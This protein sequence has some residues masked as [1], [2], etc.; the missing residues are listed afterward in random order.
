MEMNEARP[1]QSA[2]QL[3]R[4]MLE[5][6]FKK[7]PPRLMYTQY[8]SLTLDTVLEGIVRLGREVTPDFTLDEVGIN[9]YA[10]AL[11]WLLGFKHPEIDDPMKGIIV[12]GETGVGKTLMVR[13]LHEVSTRLGIHR[14]FYDG[15]SSRVCMKPFLWNY[16]THALWHVKD[17]MGSDDGSFQALR[18]RVLHIGDLGSEPDTFHRY[19]NRSSLADLINQRSD[20]GYQSAPMIITTNLPWSELERYGDRA[21]SRLRGDCIEIC[22]AGIPDHRTQKRQA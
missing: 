13:L 21:V 10:K 14:P 18:W 16:E 3:I 6:D 5:D 1:T 12:T 11:S 9:A 2:S 22:M 15:A 4:K 8:T 20:M 7:F 17:Y 19:G